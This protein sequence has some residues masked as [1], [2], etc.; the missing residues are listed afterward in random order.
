MKDHNP[1]AGDPDTW[2]PAKI[3]VKRP[4]TAVVSVR[5]P[6]ELLVS[7]EAYAQARS[8]TI[9]DAVRLATERLIKGIEQTPTFA[10]V[11]TAQSQ[12]KLAGPTVLMHALTLG[13]RPLRSEQ[14]SPPYQL[15]LI[16]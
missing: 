7:L 2:E 15:R 11:A 13:T 16:H 12:L 8:V 14:D 9:S 4:A 10:V 6:S 3:N 5:M 1:E